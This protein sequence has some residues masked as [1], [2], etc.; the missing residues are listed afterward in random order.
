MFQNLLFF[1]CFSYALWGLVPSCDIQ[2]Y[3]V[4]RQ[5]GDIIIGGIFPIHQGVLLERNNGEDF[6]CTGIQAKIS[7]KAEPETQTIQITI[8]SLCKLTLANCK[9]PEPCLQVATSSQTLKR[10]RKRPFGKARFH[11]RKRRSFNC[12]NCGCGL[13]CGLGGVG[14][15]KR[16]TVSG[17][18]VLQKVQEGHRSSHLSHLH[19]QVS[20]YYEVKAAGWLNHHLRCR[21][22]ASPRPLVDCKH[23]RQA[24]ALEIERMI[25]VIAFIYMIENINNST[26]LPGITLGYE[27]H[28][29]C[30]NALKAIQ[31]TMRL[32]PELAAYNNL[33]D[34]NHTEII[35]TVKAVV[36]EIYSENSITISRILS[37]QFIPQIS[38]ASTAAV[39]SDKVKFPSFLRTIPTDIY[40]TKAIVKLIKSFEWNWVGIIASDDDYGRSAMD[41]LNIYLKEERMCSAFSAI[42]P[43]YVEHPDV[44]GE[45]SNIINKL[46]NSSANVV[47]VFLKG[48]IVRKLFEECM[49][50]NISRTWIASDL[51]SDSREVSIMEN[52]N[53]VGTIIGLN[54]NAGQVKGFAEYLGS[55][56]PQEDGTLNNFL[57]EYKEERFG[58]TEEYKEYLECKKS[59]STDCVLSDSLK[60]KSPLACRVEN[61]S[62]VNDDY[63]LQNTEW[64]IIYSTALAV[65]AIAQAIKNILCKI[66]KCEMNLNFSPHQLLK[67]LEQNN[68]TYNDKMFY[69]NHFGSVLTGY[70]I[71]NWQ[72]IDNSTIFQI[73][74]NFNLSDEKVMID[75][76]LM[77]WNTEDNK[78]P[79]SNCSKLCSPGYSKKHSFITCCYDCIPCAEGYYSPAADTNE[80]LKCPKTHWSSNGSSQCENRTT[81]YF[82]WNNPFAIV[83]MSFTTFGFLLVITIG[84]LFIKYADTPAVK[85]AGGNYSYLLGV[86]LL[87]SLVSIVLFIGQPDDITCKVR[88]PLYGISFTICVS[89]I[90]VKSFRIL[91]AF[92]S[93]KSGKP[94]PALTYQPVVIIS[95][96]TGFQV[97]VCILWLSL[98]GPFARKF[99]TIPKLIVLQCDEGSYLPFAFMLAYI[100]FLAFACFILAYKGRKLPVKY[101]EARYITFS[102]LIYM[103]VW[104]AFIPIYMNTT[105]M[106]LSAVQVVAILASNY[107][108]ILC[109][110]LPASYIIIFKR[111]SNNRARY[112]QSV[113]AFCRV[114]RSILSVS[115]KISDNVTGNTINRCTQA[116]QN[117]STLVRKRCKSF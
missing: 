82:H 56:L 66:G 116:H 86:S 57:E 75:K 60:H 104:I 79:F 13:G 41:Y 100:G 83:L 39:L 102:M 91:L 88:Q 48:P 10:L 11:N 30:S 21:S 5:P 93:Y 12:K 74:G 42:V 35:P 9:P 54:F 99:Y 96:L 46:N 34:C 26:L 15:L 7:A 71:S 8:L 85:A 64:S 20:F 51:W 17:T 114:Q 50:K 76:S 81:E 92:E 2:N 78:V 111:K 105:G 22:V 98:K 95:V 45:I 23:W 24:A 117:Q 108:V 52:V 70:D 25:E 94:M 101:N 19:A 38:P 61:I 107:G 16:F 43:S 89:C 29:S 69:F 72:I 77:I 67:E 84:I 49:K 37:L 47:V 97:C 80:C 32:F 63:L 113:H 28:D 33:S 44:P 68:F 3:S 58:C 14:V 27:I 1:V 55:L 110:L 4:V 65:T 115:I 112:L 90:M 40:Q 106:Y 53:K 103:F 6:I 31:E 73:V 59:S 109:H 62:F 87:V 36:G 18:R